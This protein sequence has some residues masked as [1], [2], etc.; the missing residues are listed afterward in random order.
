MVNRTTGKSYTGRF[1]NTVLVDPMTHSA[2]TVGIIV[3]ITVPGSGAVLFD[4]GRLVANR[5][6]ITFQAGP[7]QAFDGDVAAV[8]AALT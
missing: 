2:A 6:G 1:H 3:R 7:H 4:V 5:S 8:C